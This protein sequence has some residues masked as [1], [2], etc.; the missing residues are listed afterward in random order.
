MRRRGKSPSEALTRPMR[1]VRGL[2]RA[3]GCRCRTCEADR[4]R[5][6]RSPRGPRGGRVDRAQRSGASLNTATRGKPLRRGPRTPEDPRATGAP[7][8]QRPSRGH[9]AGEG[10]P[11]PATGTIRTGVQ[12]PDPEA[13]RSGAR[14]RVGTGNGCGSGIGNG[15]AWVTYIHIFLYPHTSVL[16]PLT[17]SGGKDASVWA[18]VPARAFDILGGRMQ[19]QNGEVVHGI[20]VLKLDIHHT[21]FGNSMQAYGLIPAMGPDTRKLRWRHARV[22][23][24]NVTC[25][26]L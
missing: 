10:P 25:H 12:G 24:D 23:D 9:R 6:P 19:A 3:R 14:G 7:A 21:V 17:S 18:R 8:P 20:G 15:V 22:K 13:Q 1:V 4:R 11:A 26:T 5:S 16:P 2:S